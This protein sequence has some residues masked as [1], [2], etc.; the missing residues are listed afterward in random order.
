MIINNNGF[1]DSILQAMAIC[2]FLTTCSIQ[3]HKNQ[4]V[5]E[6]YVEED[7]IEKTIFLRYYWNK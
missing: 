4:T 1:T 2:V 6:Y 5:N 3:N 7:N